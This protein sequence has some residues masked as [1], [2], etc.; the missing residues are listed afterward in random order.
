MHAGTNVLVMDVHY[1]RYHQRGT[2]S[3]LE[4]A[5]NTVSNAN[6]R[7]LREDERTH[8]EDE[9]SSWAG[10]EG[11]HQDASHTKHSSGGGGARSQRQVVKENKH[12]RQHETKNMHMGRTVQDALS[13]R[14][15]AAAR[16]AMRAELE[17]EDLSSPEARRMAR[18]RRTTLGRATL[19]QEHPPP[20]VMQSVAAVTPEDVRDQCS[21]TM[22]A[23][24]HA[25]RRLLAS[26]NRYIFNHKQ[27]PGEIFSAHLR[28]SSRTHTF[29]SHNSSSS[30]TNENGISAQQGAMD[31][32]VDPQ[33]PRLSPAS[34]PAPG[35]DPQ[36]LRLAVLNAQAGHPDETLSR[37]LSQLGVG[38]SSA[39]G[40]T[41][42]PGRRLQQ[43]ASPPDQWRTIRRLVQFG[44]HEYY[45]HVHPCVS[46]VAATTWYTIEWDGAWF[47]GTPGR[48]ATGWTYTEAK[49]MCED[50]NGFNGHLAT[51][52][53]HQEL[54]FLSK[55]VAG[56]WG[57]AVGGCIHEVLCTGTWQSK[58]HVCVHRAVIC[59]RELACV[60][61]CM[62]G[63]ASFSLLAAQKKQR[64]HAHS[65]HVVKLVSHLTP[66][67]ALCPVLQG[68]RWVGRR[69][70]ASSAQTTMQRP[71][72]SGM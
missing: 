60:R 69:G 67:T 59:M 48:D 34:R 24:L 56:G 55:L 3:E 29:H 38:N 51:V 8:A 16:A 12:D 4:T 57:Y 25:A 52:T 58:T 13:R 62:H 35:L 63:A 6:Q 44:K 19:G 7:R 40:G 53:S 11:T 49:A 20:R 15:G 41:G 30:S 5:R 26:G 22:P 70:W 72:R 42:Q 9:G 45:L 31:T 68:T 32:N 36:A 33:Q 47:C 28:H 71:R 18:A 64:G 2:T 17:R 54:Q 66:T 10:D 61:A 43:S 39:A 50:V 1:L 21:V 14:A 46:F 27:D 65:A 37:N 23:A